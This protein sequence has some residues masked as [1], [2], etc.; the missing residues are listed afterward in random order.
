MAFIRCDYRSF[1][2]RGNW[3]SEFGNTVNNCDVG[4][5]KSTARIVLPLPWNAIPQADERSPSMDS[6]PRDPGRVAVGH[7]LNPRIS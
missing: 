7:F 5:R 6:I 4:V 3:I 1:E 2:E